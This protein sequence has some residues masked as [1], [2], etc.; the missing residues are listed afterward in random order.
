MDPRRPVDPA[1]PLESGR[2]SRRRFLGSAC[3]AVGMTSL[4]STAFDLRRIAAASPLVGDYRALI[5]VFLYG[6]NDSDNMIVPRGPGYPRYAKER[7]SL[8]LAAGSLRP[9]EPLGGDGRQWALHPRLAQVQSLFGQGRLA[10][11]ANVG[12]LVAP[13]TRG[14]YLAGSPA[15][16]PQLFS[17]S[18]QTLHWQ[19]AL[20]DQPA[21]S[22]WGG[23]V[24]D[25]VHSLNGNPQ[26]SMS[27]SLSGSNTFQI[28]NAVTQYQLSPDGSIGLGWYYD[29]D[30]WNHPPSTAIRKLMARSY[31][32]LFAAGYRDV[33]QRALSQDRL[34]SEALDAASPLATAFPDTDLGRQLRMVARLMS[35]RQGLGLARQVFFVAAGGYDTHDAQVEGNPQ[36]GAH[37]ELLEELDGALGAFYRATVELGLADSVTT[38]TASD[39]G[40][41]YV[42]NGDGSDHGWGAHH[43]VL[44][45]AVAGRR[46]YGTMPVLA[47]DGPDDSGDGRWIPTTSVD[48]YSATLAS[49]FGVAGGELPL[50]FPNLGRFGAPD[51]G[52]MT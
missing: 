52:F 30:D 11:V 27:M 47:V 37:A 6:G 17:H 19:T 20:P 16:P 22:G 12:P 4:A 51:L 42:C 3:A 2:W 15:V 13:L 29:G 36:Q 49:W 10:I 34:L 39:F 5:C 14:Q 7:G 21:R 44:G 28:G 32:N 8:A 46:I 38:F 31:G 25:L 9:I 24:A 43:L 23:R 33:F 40:R 45:G 18:D 1:A 35:A 26:V 48:E 41:T 50:V